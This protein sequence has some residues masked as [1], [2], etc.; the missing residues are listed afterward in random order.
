[1]SDPLDRY[2]E[3]VAIETEKIKEKQ[4]GVKKSKLPPLVMPSDLKKEIKF[5]VIGL[6]EIVD[7]SNINPEGS[8]VYGNNGFFVG[9]CGQY[10]TFDLGNGPET[11]ILACYKDGRMEV[12]PLKKG[13]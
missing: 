2:Y 4:K 7:Y 12:K 8:L 10:G 1:M 9:K 3:R 13:I 5:S 6:E 11:G